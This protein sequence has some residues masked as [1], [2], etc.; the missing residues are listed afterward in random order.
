MEMIDL[1]NQN[2]SSLKRAIERSNDLCEWLVRLS[3]T[4]QNQGQFIA[5]LQHTIDDNNKKIQEFQKIRGGN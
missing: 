5:L 1:L 3:G 2:N 4:P